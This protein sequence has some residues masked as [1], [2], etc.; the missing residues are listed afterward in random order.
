MSAPVACSGSQD[1][2]NVFMLIHGQLQ[3][4]H[5]TITGW[6]HFVTAT[7]L[8]LTPSLASWSHECPRVP[9][10]APSVSE[11]RDVGVTLGQRGVLECEVDAVPKADFEWYRDDRR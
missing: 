1:M 6:Q 5:L 7:A 10:D 2:L 9:V 11:G 8:T 4:D 3:W